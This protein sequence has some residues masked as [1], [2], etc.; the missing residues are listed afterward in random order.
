SYV[1]GSNG[2][3]T[4]TFNRIKQTNVLNIAPKFNFIKTGDIKETFTMENIAIKQY[5]LTASAS[6]EKID[7][8][9]NGKSKDLIRDFSII[10]V[11]GG[12]PN[13]VLT[14]SVS[15]HGALSEEQRTFNAQG[16]A[17]AKLSS[18]APY[19]T[20]P[21][22]KAQSIN[23]DSTKTI[24]YQLRTF[25]PVI[26]YPVFDST[27]YGKHEKTIDYDTDYSILVK[28]LL[29]DSIIEP[30]TNGVIKPKSNSVQ[31]NNKGEATIAYHKISD[32]N[33]KK[34]KPQ[35][36]YIKSGD[37]KETFTMND[38]NLYQYKLSISSDKTELVGDE[39]FKVTV[40]GG[41]PNASVEWTLTG[42][43]KITSKD[44][45]FNAKGEAY[46]NGQGKS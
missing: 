24:S 3:V 10:T 1:V 38:I 23:K 4:L 13:Q 32:F 39:I 28:G 11:S 34:I 19:T 36:K 37:T 9:I 16:K 18:K 40:R 15:G 20:N 17:T 35:F 8:Y 44:S 5:P 26:T 25:T 22:V 6:K 43:G 2:E 14:W 31:V 46:L 7:A 42:D 33:T 27:L 30:I 41:K 45:K 21:V 29:P 12:K